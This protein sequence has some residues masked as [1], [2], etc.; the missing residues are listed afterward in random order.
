MSNL[1]LIS[2][3]IP[4]TAGT[5]FYKS[6]QDAYSESHV[7]RIDFKPNLNKIHYNYKE[8]SFTKLPQE[9]EVIHGHFRIDE[10]NNAFPETLHLP[11]ITWLRDPVSRLISNYYYLIERLEEATQKIEEHKMLVRRMTK[12]L[13]EF[14]VLENNRNRM[15]SFLRGLNLVDFQFVGIVEKYDEDLNYLSQLMHKTLAKNYVNITSN[16]EKYTI[17]EDI[18]NLIIELNQEDI[19]LYK[20]ALSLRERRK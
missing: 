2:I 12:S 8:A 13:E 9:L 4:K 3:H 18:R 17:S 16:K 7:G 5:S 10:L 19:E 11:V 6:L 15:G 1:K 20:E 14:I